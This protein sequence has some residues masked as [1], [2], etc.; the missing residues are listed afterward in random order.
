MLAGLDM[1]GVFEKQL[2]VLGALK[3][4][5]ANKPKKTEILDLAPIAAELGMSQEDV[6]AEALVGAMAEIGAEKYG[7]L[8]LT[9]LALKLAEEGANTVPGTISAGAYH[10]TDPLFEVF[11]FAMEASALK[12]Y[13]GRFITQLNSAVEKRTGSANVQ[14]AK[15]E[16]VNAAREK[17]HAQ[18]RR[19]ILDRQEY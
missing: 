13:F 19:E 9:S 17:A 2:R 15:E 11:E 6:I 5:V 12:H 7:N 10:I 16:K 8:D 4:A 3:R 14:H 18:V 1:H